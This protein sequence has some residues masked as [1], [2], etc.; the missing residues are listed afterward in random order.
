M[1]EHENFDSLHRVNPFTESQLQILRLRTGWQPETRTFNEDELRPQF[2]RILQRIPAEWKK[3]QRNA[4]KA[5]DSF[6][7]LYAPTPRGK[8]GRKENAEL[9]ERIWKLDAE[10]KT[11]L[12]IKQTLEEEEGKHYSLAGIESY[13]KTRRRKPQ[14]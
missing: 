10:G 4:K 2:E 5:R 14:N 8:L 13:L 7:A 12:E 9:A 11:N 6:A 1:S 3:Y